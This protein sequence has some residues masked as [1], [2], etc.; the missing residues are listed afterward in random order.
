MAQIQSVVTCAAVAAALWTLLGWPIAARLAPPPLARFVAP[1]LGWAVYSVCALPLFSVIG[2]SRPTGLAVT[3]LSAAIALGLAVRRPWSVIGMGRGAWLALL[4]GAALFALAPAAAILP[5]ETATGVTLASPIFDHSKIAMIDEMIRSGVPGRNP[6]LG[7]T[8]TP[9]R[10]AYY[11]LWHFSAAALAVMTG[12]SGWEAD[13]ALTWFTGFASL[14][15]VAGLAV[16]LGGGRSSAGWVVLVFA[17]MASART[18]LEWIGPETVPSLIGWA[19]GFG[20]WLFQTSWA[21]QHVMSAAC[22]L[23]AGLLI[24]PL[25]DRAGWHAAIVLGLVAAASFQSSVW[26]GGVILPLGLLATVLMLLPSL[27]AERRRALLVR[28]TAAA[29]GALLLSLPFIHDQLVAGARRNVG[30]PIAIRPVEVTGAAI[31]AGIRRLVDIPAFWLIY[32]PVE[33]VAFYVPGLLGLA[34]L[35][36]RSQD[37]AV[38]EVAR[39]LAPLVGVSLGAAWVLA[40]TVGDNNDLGWRAVLPA[41]LLMIAFAAALIAHWPERTARRV[42]ALAA[43]GVLLALPETIVLVRENAFGLRKPSERVF[44]ATPALWQAVRRHTAPAERV[45]NNPLL[46]AD[47]TPWPVNISWALLANRRS[48]YA[49]YELA[50]AFA[51]ISA[52]RRAEIETQF[53]RIFAGAPM[54]GD[55][56]AMADRFHCDVVVVTPQ[57][58]AW[59]RDPFGASGVYRLVDTDADAWRIYRRAT[60]PAPR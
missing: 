40:S 14:L 55:V 7:E 46:L 26:V 29:A 51:P 58:G 9:D 57:D 48:C 24:R 11:Y 10:V 23:L 5:K 25:A 1:L 12:A 41:I 56:A 47:M 35:A 37:K 21:P 49:G 3:T 52:T 32:L 60:D 16:Q 33:F 42:A 13:A 44:A 28:G 34:W 54:P 38:R 59:Q 50:I 31:P 27:D 39:T 22:V 15:L 45:A 36:W 6:V 19:S 18:V 17:A 20:G 8:G 4:I 2:M 43:A 53:V 30:M